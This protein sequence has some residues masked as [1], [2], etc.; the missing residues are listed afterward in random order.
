M[1]YRFKRHTCLFD[2]RTLRFENYVTSILPIP[3]ISGDYAAKVSSCPMYYR[4][5]VRRLQP[6]RCGRRDSELDGQS[7]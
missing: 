2:S 3:S 5:P 4:R 7:R 1:A 6:A